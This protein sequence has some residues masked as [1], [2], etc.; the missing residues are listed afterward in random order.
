MTDGDGTLTHCVHDT[1]NGVTVT[2][3]TNMRELYAL[4]SDRMELEV[5]KLDA[6]IERIKKLQ[7]GAIIVLFCS[8]IGILTALATMS[9]AGIFKI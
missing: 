5:F 4:L 7:T 2:R 9:F 8:V 3:V 6:K 1:V